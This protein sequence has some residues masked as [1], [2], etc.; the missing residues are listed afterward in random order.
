[1]SVF[2]YN[3]LD[4]NPSQEF[5]VNMGPVLTGYGPMDVSCH[6]FGVCAHFSCAIFK[7]LNELFG[8][9]NTSCHS[10]GVRACV[11]YGVFKDLNESFGFK[12]IHKTKEAPDKL[13]FLFMHVSLHLVNLNIR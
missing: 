9:K 5:C 10:F 8:F 13:L 1:M 6:S 2:Q 4:V 7:V 12:N 11:P 3:M